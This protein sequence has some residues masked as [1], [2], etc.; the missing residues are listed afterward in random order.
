MR[1][2][3]KPHVVCGLHRVPGKQMTRK[4]NLLLLAFLDLGNVFI[5]VEC[6]LCVHPGWRRW[7]LGDRAE[8][9]DVIV[10][11]PAYNSSTNVTQFDHSALE[12]S[13]STRLLCPVD[14]AL[15][16]VANGGH[17]T[18]WECLVN[19]LPGRP[20]SIDEIQQ[21]CILLARPHFHDIVFHVF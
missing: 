19:R 10:V 9:E 17:R 4:R 1:H 8:K 5:L 6:K 3:L 16:S 11:R 12:A 18:C 2:I 21:E 15:I 14:D 20:M 7:F 13:V